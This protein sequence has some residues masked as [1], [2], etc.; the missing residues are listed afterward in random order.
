MAPLGRHA[1]GFQAGRAGTDTT[2]LRR[3][4][5]GGMSCGIVNSRPVAGLWMQ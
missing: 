4:V 3:T 1:R 2:T 5:A